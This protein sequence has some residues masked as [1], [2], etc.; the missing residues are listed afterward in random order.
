MTSEVFVIWG[1]NQYGKPDP[2]KSLGRARADLN[3][4]WDSDFD[5]RF[6]VLASS[7]DLRLSE[8]ELGKMIALDDA[9]IHYR[10]KRYE[11]EEGGS[12][13]L[14]PVYH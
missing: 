10:I 8:S 5:V 7:C 6:D 14:E 11:E 2:D 12:P 4:A 3:A 9:G 13:Y 1:T